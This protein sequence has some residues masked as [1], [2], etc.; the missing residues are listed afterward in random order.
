V[1]NGLHANEIW[2]DATAAVE[3]ARQG[4]LDYGLIRDPAV[5]LAIQSGRPGTPLLVERLDEPESAYYLIP[6]MTTEG[7]VFV[8]EVDASS[9]VM[10]EAT[11]F[12][13]P[14]LSPFLTPSEALDYVAQ[15]FPGRTFGEPRLVWRPCRE[16]TRPMRPFYQI[17]FDKGVLYVDMDGSIFPE[18][19]P[20][21]FGGESCP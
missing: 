5:A 8:V 6:W 7:V 21:G 12:P 4:V 9:G 15:K 14:T 2:I 18:P 16:S 19:T 1:I 11:T 3:A 13:K 10:L 17:P 20:L